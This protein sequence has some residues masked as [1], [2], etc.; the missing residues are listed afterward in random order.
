MTVAAPMGSAPL[1]PPSQSTAGGHDV[2]RLNGMHRIRA[3][4]ERVFRLELTALRVRAAERLAF[5]GPTGSGKSSLIEVIAVAQA[6]T[7]VERFEIRRFGDERPI[8]LGAAWDRQDDPFLTRVRA[9]SFGYVQQV[10]GLL[11]FLTVRDNIALSLDMLGRTDRG[12]VR[13]LAAALD[14][15]GMLSAYPG[16]LSVGQ[17]Q[18]V[19]VARALVHEPAIV[20]ADEPTAALD[21]AMARRVMGLMTDAAE[22]AGT[23]LILATHDEDLAAEFGFRFIRAETRADAEA[24]FTRFADPEA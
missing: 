12:R 21:L 19:A 11:G 18:R 16:D 5:V 23:C 8:D 24:Q 6:P 9:R 4:R 22:R 10:G 3:D 1:L 20:L 7:R 2:L 13:D 15:A 17:R 14:V